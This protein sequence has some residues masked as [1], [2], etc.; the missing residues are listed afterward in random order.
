M[1][2][3]VLEK[4][5]ETEDVFSLVLEKPD[6]FNFYHGQYL[7][8]GLANDT[9][10]FTISS[11]PTENFIMITTK[12]GRSRFKKMMEELKIGD[13]ITTSHPAGTFTLDESSPAIFLAGGIGITPFRSMIKYVLDKQI[14]TSMTLIYSAKGKFA[15]KTELDQWKK[16][17]PNLKINYLNTGKADRLNRQKLLKTLDPASVYYL[18]GSHSFVD[19]LEQVLLNLVVDKTSVRTDR[20][21]GY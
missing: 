12:K 5:W 1:I 4:K 11:S 9:R 8:I 13:L 19:N 10:A 21:D 7:D 18:V 16:Q 6:N 20:F 2:L 17:L 15:F 3:K 14:S